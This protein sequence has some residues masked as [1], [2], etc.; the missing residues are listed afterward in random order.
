MVTSSEDE[1]AV[2]GY[3]EQECSSPSRGIGRVFCEAKSQKVSVSPLNPKYSSREQTFV[4]GCGML[5]SFN[6]GFSNGLALSGL[7]TPPDADVRTQGTSGYSGVTTHSA[8]ALASLAVGGSP[9]YRQNERVSNLTYFGFQTT[10]ILAFVVGSMISGL[11]NPRPSPWRLA[12]QYAPPFFFVYRI[13]VHRRGVVQSRRHHLDQRH[14]DALLLLCRARQR[15]PK[16]YLQ[17]VF[18]QFDPDYPCKRRLDL[19]WSSSCV[20]IPPTCGSFAS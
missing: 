18:G 17:H 15:H 2:E 10:M 3:V 20:G 12:P 1:E 8:L 4:V 5:L 14:E 13:H 11:L 7:L 6:S 9:Q 19:H 16:W